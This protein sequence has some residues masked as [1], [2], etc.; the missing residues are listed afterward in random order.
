MTWKTHIISIK[1]VPIS[2]YI[3]YACT[4]K[5]NRLTRIALLPIGY[6]D[7]Y[8]FE[9]SNKTSVL[10]NGSYAPI[11]GRVAMN[12]IIVDITD[13]T[14]SIDDEVIILGPY[15]HINAHDLALKA[16]ITNIREILVGINPALKRIITK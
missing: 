10:I 6:F 15:P 1:T 12:M 7:G 11:I 16:N 13:I 2:S 14:A 5:T 3:G 9:F 4:Y 8:K